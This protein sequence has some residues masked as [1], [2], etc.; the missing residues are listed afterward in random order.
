[1][2]ELFHTFTLIHGGVM[3][4]SSRRSGPLHVYTEYVGSPSY[5]D[6]LS[7]VGTLWSPPETIAIAGAF[8]FLTYLTV[9][10]LVAVRSSL[11]ATARSVLDGAREREFLARLVGLTDE[12]PWRGGIRNGRVWRSV[13][14]T[15]TAIN[16]A[17]FLRSSLYHAIHRSAVL[18]GDEKL[19][20][21]RQLDDAATRLVL[22]QSLDIGRHD[23]WF[24][25]GRDFPYQRMVSWKTGSLFGC[26][27]A[28]AAHAARL[29]DDRVSAARCDHGLVLSAIRPVPDA[30]STG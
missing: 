15:S 11:G 26:A 20:M 7:I 6:D 29:D 28:M 18:S 5:V 24:D 27:A 19:V 13:A 8:I 9:P 12:Q 17:A 30:G 4:G 22:G 25:A 1:M 3:D 21:R 10:T 23:G 16:V 2:P 14:D